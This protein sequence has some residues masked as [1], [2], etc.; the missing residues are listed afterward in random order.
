M[1][2]FIFSVK[3]LVLTGLVYTALMLLPLMAFTNKWLYSLS[4]LAA[5]LAGFRMINIILTNYFLAVK[6]SRQFCLKMTVLTL[7][8][9]FIGPIV[10]LMYS[11]DQST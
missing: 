3:Y 2:Y 1:N 8:P 4:L 9:P 7:I 11:L 5:A 10:V 6:R